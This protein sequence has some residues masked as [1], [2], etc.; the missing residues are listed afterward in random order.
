MTGEQRSGVENSH[1]L[2]KILINSEN[3][4]DLNFYLVKYKKKNTYAAFWKYGCFSKKDSH[5]TF[6]NWSLSK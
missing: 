6:I 2:I 4:Y 1:A 5:E 3:S